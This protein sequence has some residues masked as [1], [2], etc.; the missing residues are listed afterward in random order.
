MPSPKT[1]T[2]TTD[3]AGVIDSLKKGKANFKNDNSGN[4]HQIIGKASFDTEKLVENYEALIVAINACKTEAHK[5]Q[6]VSG[7]SM[8]STMGPSVKVK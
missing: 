6:L 3:V 2:V 8:C 7:I 1:D 4:I 5:G